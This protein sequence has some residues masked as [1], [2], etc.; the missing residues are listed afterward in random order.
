[1]IDYKTPGAFEQA[2][3]AHLKRQTSATG[4]LYNRALQMAVFDRFLE[5]VYDALGDAVVLKGGFALEL[6]LPGTRTTR[7][8]DL[9][10][11]GDL[12]DQLRR[13][14][15]RCNVQ[16]D[17][18]LTFELGEETTFEELHGNQLVYGGRRVR[19]QCLLAARP[20]GAPFSLDI[21]VGDRLVEPPVEVAGT[22]LF[23]FA[24]IPPV[25]HRIY[26]ASSHVAEKLHAYT[27]PRDTPNSRVKD[28]VDIALLARHT[29]FDAD[30]L[31]R[32]VNATF[33]F[34]NTH[35]APDAV[36]PPPAFWTQQYENLLKRDD[37]PFPTI[38]ACHD[39][40]AA[41]L[42][43]ILDRS[44]TTSTWASSHWKRS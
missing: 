11:E 29:T 43:P 39:L 27:L 30:T 10:A 13:L 9:R 32:A 25:T 42:N 31:R 5:R 28:L 38:A 2:L 35:P 8:V 22:D 44:L 21:A 7:D 17:D 41:L 23:E 33:D 37:L 36:P 26:P 4:E 3:K 1:M 19:V 34:R 14:R 6:R 20:L 16:G 40:A 18:F 12:G 15:V 24:D